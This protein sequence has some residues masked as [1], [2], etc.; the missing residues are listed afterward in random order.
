MFP[1][2]KNNEMFQN[3]ER[4][5]IMYT[6]HTGLTNVMFNKHRFDIVGTFLH[7][8]GSSEITSILLLASILPSTFSYF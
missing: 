7:L 1:N 2:F 3:L 6:Y 5:I 4:I 8:P